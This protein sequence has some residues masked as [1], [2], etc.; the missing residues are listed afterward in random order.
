MGTGSD[1]G[2][3]RRED[4]ARRRGRRV[5]QR[6]PKRGG[7]GSAE[8]EQRKANGQR[9]PYGLSGGC[10]PSTP[11]AKTD[12]RSQSGPIVFSSLVARRRP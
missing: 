6:Q 1:C 3:G 4:A 2:G 8:D 9:R 7:L 11:C 10:Y 12:L 5:L